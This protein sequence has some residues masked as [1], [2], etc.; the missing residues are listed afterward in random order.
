MPRCILTLMKILLIPEPDGSG[1]RNILQKFLS[2]SRKKQNWRL[3]SRDL[4]DPLMADAV[5]QIGSMKSV[6]TLPAAG[7]Q[8]PVHYDFSPLGLAAGNYFKSS[9]AISFAYIAGAGRQFESDLL[10]GFKR[11]LVRGHQRIQVFSVFQVLPYKTVRHFLLFW[12]TFQSPQLLLQ[13]MILLGSEYSIC[14]GDS[15]YQFRITFL[16]L[17]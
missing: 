9:G 2:Y 13:P 11:G 3:Y 12:N 5:V 8:L 6:I 15:M 16:Y 17:V 7:L 4:L 10:R 1:V 14:A